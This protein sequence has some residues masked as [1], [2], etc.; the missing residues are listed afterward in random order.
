LLNLW[1]VP[2]WDIRGAAIA[3]SVSYLLMTALQAG[4]F[5]VT[6]KQSVTTL[7]WMRRSDWQLYIDTYR[8]LK[9]RVSAW[10]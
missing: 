9:M 3:S 1:L 8:L 6:T 10:R 2:V 5:L 4:W 7:L